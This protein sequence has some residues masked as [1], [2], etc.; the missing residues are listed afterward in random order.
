MTAKTTG[1]DERMVTLD[2]RLLDRDYKVACKDGEEAELLEAVA[3]LDQRMRD[4]REGSKASSVERTA[5]MAALN[6][7]HEF[8][9]DRSSP[10]A[11]RAVTLPRANALQLCRPRSLTLRPRG[12]ESPACA[13]R[14]IRRSRSRKNC[15]EA[16][17]CFSR[18]GLRPCSL[19]C[20]SC[21]YTLW[22]N[23]NLARLPRHLRAG[24]RSYVEAPEGSGRRPS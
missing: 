2:V 8:L 24:V 18:H 23:A 15:F 13:P 6:I 7:A 22:T 5:V 17:C 20:S 19:R 21:P 11:D 16:P 12:V 9:R 10:S 14:S 1:S 4:I 3:F